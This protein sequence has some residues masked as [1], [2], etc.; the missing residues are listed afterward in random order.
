MRS[1]IG[2]VSA[3]AML[4]AQ[5]Q[6]TPAF[7]QTT[8]ALQ[9]PQTSAKN[10]AITEAFAQFPKGGDLLAKRIADHHSCQSQSR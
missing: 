8:A 1:I 5:I 4:V 2:A 10:S 6:P 3:V 7:A 9:V